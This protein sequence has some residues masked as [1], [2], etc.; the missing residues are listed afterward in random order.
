MKRFDKIIFLISICFILLICIVNFYISKVSFSN[1][2]NEY[3]ISINRIKKEIVNYEQE[4]GEPALNLY[5]LKEF[6]NNE[7]FPDIMELEYIEIGEKDGSVIADFYDSEYDYVCFNTDE[8]CYR[9][10]YVNNKGID[11][12]KIL[13]IVN[14][15]SLILFF[16]TFVILIYIRNNLIKPFNQLVELPYELSKGNLNIPLKESKNRFFGRFMWGMDLLREKLEENKLRELELQREKKML[17]LSLSHDIKTPLSAIKLYAKALSRNL[18]KDENKKIEVV[19]NIDEKANEIETYIS[20]IVKASND[21]FLVFEVEN[22]ELYIKD[23]LEFINEYYTDKMQLNNIDFRIERYKNCIVFG[24]TSR[25]IEV[26]QNIVENAIKYGDGKRI[27]ISTHR[28]DDCYIISIS[29]TGCVLDE[30]ELIHIFDSFFRGSNVSKKPGSGL[31]LYIC[32]ELMHLMEGEVTANIELSEN[33]RIM[34]VNII[35]PLV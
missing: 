20:E 4:R 25:L 17:L 24:D 35:V 9:I 32:R 27:W 2:G 7:K 33:E 30:K 21:D 11:S 13:V 3:Q 14:I 29:N 6:T 31:G 23:V 28:E 12:T 15:F 19:T 10:S 22:K 5:E 34:T 18:Y 16:V 26:V 1:N 8:Y